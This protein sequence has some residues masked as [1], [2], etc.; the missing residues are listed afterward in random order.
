MGET[1]FELSN[2]RKVFK[3]GEEAKPFSISRELGLTMGQK[4]NLRPSSR[5][6]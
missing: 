4:S 1:K 6:T 2:E 3:E 5:A